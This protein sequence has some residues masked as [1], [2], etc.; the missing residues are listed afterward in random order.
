MARRDRLVRQHLRTRFL[1]TAKSGQTW[2]AVLL[3]ADDRSVILTDV[4]SV[5]P[6][7]TRTSVVGQVFLPRDDIAYMQRT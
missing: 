4:E 6:D 2:N 7:G 3:D 5:G 1:V